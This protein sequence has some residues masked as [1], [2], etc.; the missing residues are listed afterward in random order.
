MSSN[1]KRSNRYDVRIELVRSVRIVL[2]ATITAL[3]V[4]LPIVLR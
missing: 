2:V 4:T 1:A 3:T